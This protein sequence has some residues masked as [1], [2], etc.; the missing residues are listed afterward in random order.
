VAEI[1]QKLDPVPETLRDLIVTGAEGNPFFIEELIKMLV[2]D[3]VIVVGEDHWRLEPS[4]LT[5]V[6][7]PPT[8]TG[9]LQ[10]RLDR[11]PLEERTTLQ[12]A[13]VV[14]RLFWDR[15]VARIKAS[16]AED[17]DPNDIPDTL[18]ALRGREMVFRR[19]TSAFAGAREYIFKHALLRQVTYESVLKRLRQTYHGL[20]ADWLLEQGGERVEEV[21]GLI[22]DHL[23]LAGR[24]AEAVDHL[25]QAGDRARGL[26]AH[27]EAIH[28]YERALILLK[29][30][31]DDERAARTLMRLGLTYH[32][33]FD[34]ER[35]HQAHEEG[36]A[37]WQRAGS[38]QPAMS[39]APAPHALRQHISEPPTL[40]PGLAI[41]ATS[42]RIIDHLFSGLVDYTPELSIVPDVAA[43]WQVFDGGCRYVFHLR[44]DVVWS[45]GVPLT[46][47]DFEY[48]WRRVLDPASGSG[49]ARQLYDIKG[50][51]AFHEGRLGILGVRALDDATLAVELEGPAGYFLHLL[52][53]NATYPVPRH[54]VE[55]C[56]PAWVAP[57]N[58]VSNGPFT[59]AAWQPGKS[60]V[61]ERYPQYHGPAA[62]NLRRVQLAIL[63]IG[64]SSV[65]LE[66]Y[67][68]GLLDVFDLAAVTPEE[69]DRMRKLHAP[70]YVSLPSAGTMFL[71]FDSARPP[72]D[73]P[74]V[75]RAFAHALDRDAL[76]NEVWGAHFLPP[77]GGFV[78]PG[79]PGHLPG[80]GLPYDPKRA[81][82]LLAEAGYPGGAGF[83]A[84][85]MLTFIPV[86]EYWD[87]LVAQWN[88]NLGVE[89]GW[90]S[91]EWAEYLDRVTNTP[92]RIYFMGW[93]S[94]YP[95]PDN[96]LRVAL[97]H[98]STWRHEQYLEIIERAKHALNQEERM[99]L[100]AEAQRILAKEVP[101]LPLGYDRTHLLV[102]PWVRR[103][104]LSVIGGEFWKDVVLE[105]H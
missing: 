75:R 103:Y 7:V 12:Q 19:E 35:A 42:V 10:A 72:F 33:A 46:A 6:Q 62:G 97:Q 63:P 34:F 51:R 99:E 38:A 81:R 14:G 28:A 76:V 78:P 79:M 82:E 37:L 67:Q 95:D 39:L 91:L 25:L 44:G 41:D 1:L 100:Y 45:D 18:S 73:V 83:P 17:A 16:A 93:V 4:R 57:E 20:V 26:Y 87:P 74:Q 21:T 59:L 69:M 77:T 70:E 36:F 31:E 94:D 66:M 53:C 5:Q 49:L 3:G 9:V 88:D 101:I 102:K 15:A 60:V 68:A 71:A 43:S 105:V 54:V 55:R 22:A 98:H 64:K 56:G 32:A 13:S 30:M 92:P 48:A 8:L 40:D 80:I 96:Y 61:L 24:A 104:P 29:E 27:R 58:L 11:L 90:D 89:I 23:A 47:G 85:E 2:E 52:A 65:P 84:T 50:A 86:P